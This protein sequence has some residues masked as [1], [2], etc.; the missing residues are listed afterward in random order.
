M[1]VQHQA[2]KAQPSTCVLSSNVR[3]AAALHLVACR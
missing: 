1:Y 2:L 3:V